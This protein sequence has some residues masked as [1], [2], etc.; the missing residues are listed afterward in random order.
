[1][2]NR[3]LLSVVVAVVVVNAQNYNN[4]QSFPSNAEIIKTIPNMSEDISD[5]SKENIQAVTKPLTRFSVAIV[6]IDG[7]KIVCK[8]EA[9]YHVALSIY[10]Q[11]YQLKIARSERKMTQED[12]MDTVK[13]LTALLK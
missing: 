7:E 12:Y 5:T 6:M 1:M 10:N 9:E 2:F 3:I 4:Y 11:V 13:V 8:T